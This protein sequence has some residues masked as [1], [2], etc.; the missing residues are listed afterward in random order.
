MREEKLNRLL[1]VSLI[2]FAF[3]SSNP[4]FGADLSNVTDDRSPDVLKAKLEDAE[5]SY[6]DGKID[7]AIQK[8]TALLDVRDSSVLQSDSVAREAKADLVVY[9]LKAGN[10]DQSSKLILELLTDLQLAMP[11]D[12]K[13][14]TNAADVI[15]DSV[16]SL[17]DYFAE[18]AKRLTEKEETKQIIDSLIDNTVPKDY[19]A[20]LKL[21]YSRMDAVD[22]ELLELKF[23]A[24]SEE[25]KYGDSISSLHEPD[26]ENKSDPKLS[27]EKLEKLDKILVELFDQARQMPLGDAR[28]SLGIYRLALVAN[29]AQRYWQAELF[30]QQALSQIK[31]INNGTASLPEIK[32]ALAYAL[33]RQD[34]KKEFNDLKD[35][36]VKNF[37]NRER[38]LV[39]LAR[40]CEAAGENAEAVEIYKRLLDS[41][42]QQGNSQLPEWLDAY[43]NLLKIMAPN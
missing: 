30:A 17:K 23:A 5:K 18:V 8:A 28:A 37:D 21:Y 24:D 6:R 12:P 7:V 14:S 32:L 13:Y 3:L 35:D 2:V 31:A 9:Q 27:A 25:L 1:A 22:R 40:F 20:Q 29:C 41:R 39:S 33:L 10:A 16:Q 26:S 19:R 11:M 43:N 38:V 34:K 36:I 15:A 42:K 4:A